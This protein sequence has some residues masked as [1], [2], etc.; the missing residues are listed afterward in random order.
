MHLSS[1][2]Y[3]ISGDLLDYEFTS[4]G[5]NGKIRKGVRFFEVI[6][7]VYNIGFGDIDLLTGE[8]DDKARTN[9]DDSRKIL[10]TIAQIV[11][12]F[13]ISHKD[14]VIVAEGNSISR[15]R[16][17]RMGINNNWN[18]ISVG[19]DVFGWIDNEWISFEKEKEFKKFLV[20]RKKN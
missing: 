12:D 2:P 15:N 6:K 17:Y 19:F 14:V 7:N 16:F 3:T 10:A 8:I 9:N 20:R 5:P 13:T 4:I 18:A 1:Y 11:D